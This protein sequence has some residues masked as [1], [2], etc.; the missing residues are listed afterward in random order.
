MS[1]SRQE[2]PK[3]KHGLSMFKLQ[4]TISWPIGKISAAT[5][6]DSILI[7]LNGSDPIFTSDGSYFCVRLIPFLRRMNPIFGP[8]L[9]FPTAVVYTTPPQKP[10]A[11]GC[12]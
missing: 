10:A 3:M 12:I 8:V 9:A 5:V 7:A 1:A 4:A 11:V 2:I 6:L